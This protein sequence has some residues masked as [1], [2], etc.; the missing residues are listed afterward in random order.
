MPM[1][2]MLQTRHHTW[3]NPLQQLPLQ[4]P[5]QM[6]HGYSAA[7]PMAPLV[8]QPGQ[9]MPLRQLPASC[10]S[11]HKARAQWVWAAPMKRTTPSV[12][13]PSIPAG[14]AHTQ[15]T[16]K[17]GTVPVSQ[18]PAQA[19]RSEASP[20]VVSVKIG[21]PQPRQDVKMINGEVAPA[22][23]VEKMAPTDFQHLWQ[24]NLFT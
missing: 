15:A 9:A 5:I 13:V 4:L 14:P 24:G 11:S 20:N 7:K 23:G 18:A 3:M 16:V 1:T 8:A 19:G 6:M 12:K 17:I 22:P 2:P 10:H 21:A